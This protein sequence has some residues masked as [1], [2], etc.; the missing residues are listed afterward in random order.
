MM[1]NFVSFEFT[2]IKVTN[3]ETF[4]QILIGTIIDWIFPTNSLTLY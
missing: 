4:A 1:M 2:K 3:S